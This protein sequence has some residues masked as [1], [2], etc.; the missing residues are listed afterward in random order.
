[1]TRFPALLAQALLAA[2][3]ALA[4]PLAAQPATDAAA[5]LP[6]TV[7][8]LSETAEVKRAPDEVQASLRAEARGANA[9]AVQ[10]QVN[11][12]ME[13]ALAAARAVPGLHAATG[14]YW[15]SRVDENRGW[16]ASQTLNLRA[17]EPAALL[18]LVG[19][20]QGQGLVLGDLGWRLSRGA[21]AS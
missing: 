9:A 11:R 21:E 14:G 15:T 17:A 16:L 10:G 4:T 7:L 18:E 8:S 2:G 6:E 19:G 13:Q 1:M 3:L 12:A 20:L 5:T